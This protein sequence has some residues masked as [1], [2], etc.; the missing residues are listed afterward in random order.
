[1]V[2]RLEL[3]TITVERSEVRISV[4]R[5]RMS[6]T[7]PST[8]ETFT[9]SPTFTGRSISRMIPATK[10]WTICCRPKPMPTDSAL[11]IRAICWKPRPATPKAQTRATPT[12]R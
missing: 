11:A 4:A 2:I 9:Q 3:G 6:I 7:S 5:T 10:F 12:P 1:M 8:P